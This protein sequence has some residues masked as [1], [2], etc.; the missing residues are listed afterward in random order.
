MMDLNDLVPRQSGL[1]LTAGEFINDRGEIAAS[2]VLSNGDHHAILLV[3][4]TD[5]TGKDECGPHYF[6]SE[7]VVPAQPRTSFAAKKLDRSI[8]LAQSR[9]RV[10]RR[11]QHLGTLGPIPR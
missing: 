1:V 6:S 7:E 3:P 11:F 9:A 5:A 10:L 2:G 4:C 8:M